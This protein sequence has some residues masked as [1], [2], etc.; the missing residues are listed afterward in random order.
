MDGK[1]VAPS[2]QQQPGAL[3]AQRPLENWC[4]ATA[5]GMIGSTTGNIPIEK[6]TM[7]A[8]SENNDV[9]MMAR[10]SR[11]ANAVNHNPSAENTLILEANAVGASARLKLPFFRCFSRI[12]VASHEEQHV[13]RKQQPSAN[14]SKQ[15]GAESRR[16]RS[17]FVGGGARTIPCCCCSDLVGSESKNAGTHC[18]TPPAEY[19]GGITCPV[20]IGVEVWM[21]GTTLEVE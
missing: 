2:E 16:R 11:N 4:T 14:R 8:A 15:S 18:R 13:V 21:T 17:G 1:V 6:V 12:V 7:S 5:N 19:G 20:T 9:P 10:T 3:R